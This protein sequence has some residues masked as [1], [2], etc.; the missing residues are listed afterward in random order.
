MCTGVLSACIALVLLQQSYPS[1]EAD[2]S[3]LPVALKQTSKISSSWSLGKAEHSLLVH[4]GV[5][6]QIEVVLL[7]GVDTFAG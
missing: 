4:V 7:E 2:V 6:N 5:Y 3:K 1:A